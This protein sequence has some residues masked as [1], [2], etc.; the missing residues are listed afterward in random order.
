MIGQM[1]LSLDE[2]DESASKELNK[3]KDAICDNNFS[4]EF[5]ILR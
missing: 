4:L 3:W 2:K 1:G 5:S